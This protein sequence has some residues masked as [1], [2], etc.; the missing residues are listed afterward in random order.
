MT[1]AQRQ[2]LIMAAAAAVIVLIIVALAFYS[3]MNP[4]V[5]NTGN[6]GVTTTPQY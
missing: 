1:W 6:I 2:A 4:E 5:P 3:Q